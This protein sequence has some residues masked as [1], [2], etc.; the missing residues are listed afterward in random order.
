MVKMARPRKTV[1]FRID[2][3]L[4]EKLKVIADSNYR[5]VNAELEL[6]AEQLVKDYEQQNGPI[7]INFDDSDLGDK[8]HKN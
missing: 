3:I 6:L 2:D 8:S 7:R 1:P 5:S 4:Y